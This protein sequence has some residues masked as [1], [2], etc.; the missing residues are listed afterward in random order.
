MEQAASMPSNHA[1]G[2][3]SAEALK[4]RLLGKRTCSKDSAHGDLL[5]P[6][7]ARLPAQV[8]YGC[9]G[10]GACACMPYYKCHGNSSSDLC[11][12]AGN[13][14]AGAPSLSQDSFWSAQAAFHDHTM[15]L[16]S[17]TAT[18]PPST[19]GRKALTILALQTLCM[20]AA[21]LP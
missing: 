4:G 19:S 13:A 20:H 15:P 9:K 6:C 17:P 16:P 10:H 11:V 18:P 1:T 5:T 21:S 8:W 3:T 12:F 2:G 14:F 7:A